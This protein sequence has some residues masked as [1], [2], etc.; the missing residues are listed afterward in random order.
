MGD[1]HQEYELAIRIA[2]EVEKSFYNSTKLTRKEL[3][4]ITKESLLTAKA[5]GKMGLTQLGHAASYVKETFS[6][7]NLKEIKP[8]FS[9][10]ESAAI[11]TFQT[12]R[13]AALTSGAA[14]TTG[15]VASVHVGSEFESAFA[16]VKKTVTASNA[17]LEAMRDAIRGMAKN[18]LPATAAEL[19]AIAESAG[20][21]GIHNENII[22]FTETMANMDVATNLNSEEAAEEFAKFANITAMS[23][24]NFDNLGSS[25]VALGNNMA[26]TE[27]DIVAMGMRIAAAGHQ[28][29]LS[30]ADIMAYSAALSSVGIEAEAGGTA[31]SKLLINLQMAVETGKNLKEYAAVAGMT[32]ADFSQVFGDDTT[33]AVNAFLSG[34]NDTERNGKS[35]IAVLDEMEI[36]EAR[37]RDT[38]LRAGNAS[39][40]F[41]DALDISNKAWEEN[42]ALAN[43]AE[44]RYKTFES[45]CQMTK[46]KLT[47]IGISVYDDLR[48]ALTEGVGLANE[49]ISNFA[50]RIES[51]MPIMIR[52]TK[53]AAQ[54]LGDFADPFLKVGGWLAD[55][56]GLLIGTVTG[57]GSSLA[58]YKVVSG[59]KSLT[60]ALGA[61]R[62][63]PTAGKGIMAMGAVAGII[64][65]ISSAVKKAA[66]DAKQANLAAHF[67]DISLSV[68][69]LQETAAAVLQNQ[70]IDKLRESISAMGEV[71][72]I[73]DDIMLAT[74]ELNRMDWKVSIGMELTEDAQEEYQRQ[75]ESFV[76]RTQELLIQDQYALHLSVEVLFGDDEEKANE[77]KRQINEFYGVKQEELEKERTELEKIISKAREDGN[78]SPEETQEIADQREKVLGIQRGVLGDE[79]ESNLNLISAKY[80]KE[81]LDA[82]SFINLQAEIQEQKSQMMADYDKDYVK[83]MSIYGAMLSAGKE[84]GGWNRAEYDA[85]VAD[86]KEGRLLY[87]SGLQE[88]AVQFQVGTI[89]QM[90]GEELD[91]VLEQLQNEA[92]IQLGEM[93]EHVAAG[94]P[95][96]HFDLLPE[97]IMD[98]L[99]LD[100]DQATKSAM[101]ELYERMKP[102]LE[103]MQEIARQYEE[104]GKEIPDSVRQGL[105]DMASIGAL[106]G[107]VDAM[108]VVLGDAAESPEYQDVIKIMEE[109]GGY[110]PATLAHGIAGNQQV[111]DDAVMQSARDTQ[112]AY[113]R[114]FGNSSINVSLPVS[115]L[116]NGISTAQKKLPGH[117][118]GGIF[119]APHLA[120]VAE[121]GYPESIIPLNGS[122]EA[123]DL[124][125]KTGELLGMNGLSGGPEPLIDDISEL[126]YSGGGE[127]MVQIDNSRIIHY[128]GS[129]SSRE[130]LEAILEDENEKFARLMERYL[131]NNGRMRFYD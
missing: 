56:P 3:Q 36:K 128:N 46:N 89:K 130:E 42:T 9:G 111:I 107:D 43:E 95:N 22:E 50:E 125:L 34:L 29:N 28:I 96:A 7:K 47:D 97:N 72:E 57:I 78:I 58:A 12:I 60:N 73:A 4:D 52:Q 68:D 75:I 10:M 51:S 83:A 33:K 1:K 117:K 123:I 20:Q 74:R 2:G 90:Y 69:E 41:A 80:Q 115:V 105:L 61:L 35:A 67:G 6:D 79:Y 108:W 13:A 23:Q 59:V 131:S 30:E 8:F 21:L 55:N 82:D 119:D 124:W 48:P 129:D 17:E 15:F 63:L 62:A 26:T 92:E 120:W 18:D 87:E 121:A 93:L 54:A 16:G 76:E 116:Q 38:L 101:A 40:M 81:V 94:G 98:S 127:T 45:Q 32:E 102:E 114:F 25:V 37:L 86:L 122:K 53:E 84:N 109:I 104:A 31:F 66:E 14:I 49:F 110:F 71:G 103:Q 24:E 44:Q 88:K 106:S 65:G 91:G 118:D 112:E 85:E 100:I 77:V 113:N 70:N 99:E 19:S 64:T 11:K 126:A 39:S 27:S 5:L